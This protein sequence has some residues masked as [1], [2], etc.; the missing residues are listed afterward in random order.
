MYIIVPVVCLVGARAEKSSK[1]AV[2]FSLDGRL[3]EMF[4]KEIS[5]TI[6]IAWRT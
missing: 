2:V 1:I 6:N 4:C 5:P 3:E